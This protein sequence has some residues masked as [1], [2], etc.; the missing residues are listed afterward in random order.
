MRVPNDFW[1][2]SMRDYLRLGEICELKWM[3]RSVKAMVRDCLRSINPNDQ[4][5]TSPMYY[6]NVLDHC[7]VQECSVGD[8]ATH[9]YSL[10]TVRLVL[11]G[12][13]QQACIVT[14][15][16]RQVFP[17]GPP[18]G[19]SKC[20]LLEQ[21]RVRMAHNHTPGA[22]RPVTKIRLDLSN[23][24]WNR[25]NPRMRTPDG[26]FDP[27]CDH[28]VRV[29]LPRLCRKM[30]EGVAATEW[31]RRGARLRS[32]DDIR[33]LADQFYL[34]VTDHGTTKSPHLARALM[35]RKLVTFPP[36]ANHL[37]AS[38]CPRQLKPDPVLRE[39]Y[40]TKDPF[41]YTTYPVRNRHGE[42]IGVRHAR[43]RQGDVTSDTFVVRVT[44]LAGGYRMMLQCRESLKLFG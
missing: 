1:K 7:E 22:L 29:W 28:F 13:T 24:M 4:L 30:A 21:S 39:V 6:T 11:K 16:H 18:H 32:E 2:A 35:T 15:F 23:K 10:K 33:R 42:R 37:L 36:Q 44:Q 3:S 31:G 40:D 5:R 27:D 14:P 17:W 20:Q 34:D 26:R 41:Q 43:I 9:G 8:P 19:D 25:R 38:G 12:T